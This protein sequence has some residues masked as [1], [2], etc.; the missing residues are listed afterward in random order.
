MMRTQWQ[1]LPRAHT[2]SH[3]DETRLIDLR[4]RNPVDSIRR[5][6]ACIMPENQSQSLHTVFRQAMQGC[7][8]H[9]RKST[10]PRR[11]SPAHSRSRRYRLAISAIPPYA[12]PTDS[13]ETD[14]AAP[15]SSAAGAA[16]V[17]AMAAYKKRLFYMARF[18]PFCIS[19][20]KTQPSLAC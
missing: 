17:R 19:H 14:R 15:T 7:A 9:G 20:P 1:K 3:V 13:S 12:G 11:Y 6:L 16:Y 10:Q 8:W 2:C 4:D 18:L 5:F